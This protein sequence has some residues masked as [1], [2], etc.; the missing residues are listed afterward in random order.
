M[1]DRILIKD[2]KIGKKLIGKN[3]PLFITSEIGVTCNYDI[4]ITKSLIDV[5][6]AAGA[7]AVKLIFWFPEEI[8]SDKT[9]TYTY[10]TINGPVTENLFN[11]VDKLKFSLDQ[12]H[13]IKEHADKND[14][15][16]FS[17]VNSPSGIE[18]AQ[19][20]G[21]EAFK[22]SSWDYN[23]LDLWE[24]L[25]K[26]NKPMIIDTGPVD[27]LGIAKVLNIM[28]KSKNLQSI[29]VHCF[30]TDNYKKMNMNSIPFME[31]AFNSL[32]GY[33]SNNQDSETDILSIALGASFLEKRLTMSRKLKGHHHFLS[34]EPEEFEGYVKKMRDLHSSLG[35]LDIVPPKEDLKIKKEAFRHLVANKDIQEGELITEEMLEAKRPEG[36]ISP[37]YFKI[38]IGKKAKKN[39]KYNEAI[40]WDD[41]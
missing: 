8:F 10:E 20:I 13:Q 34:M 25:A 16:L 41:I 29:L 18:Y 38:F 21:L 22:I 30:H 31:K 33:S 7:D 37:E 32:V 9:M 3:Q 12:W 40:S 14:I 23:Y 35:K 15:I 5:T 6:K 17:T 19:E 4:E 24:R 36:G 1:E 39:I 11:M 26:L 2:I 27:V 28:K